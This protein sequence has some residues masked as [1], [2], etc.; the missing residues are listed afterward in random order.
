MVGTA[1][2]GTV[3]HWKSRPARRVAQGGHQEF[4]F[5]LNCADL[6]VKTVAKLTSQQPGDLAPGVIPGSSWRGASRCDFYVWPGRRQDCCIDVCYRRQA[7]EG[8]T[9]S[10]LSAPWIKRA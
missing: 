4:M 6:A 8:S 7:N 5:I 1:A 9:R 10:R 2:R 3:T